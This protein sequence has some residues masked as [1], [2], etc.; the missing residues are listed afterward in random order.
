ATLATAALV[1]RLVSIVEPSF[2][3]FQARYAPVAGTDAVEHASGPRQRS[4]GASAP[5]DPD[6]AD[7]VVPQI[8]RFGGVVRAGPQ[9][10]R[11]SAAGH[12]PPAA[13][14]RRRTGRGTAR[15][16]RSTPSAAPTT[17]P[18][19]RRATPLR[20]PGTGPARSGQRSCA[21]RRS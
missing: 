16:A 11:G 18:W 6:A 3:V 2:G 20:S 5:S 13:R 15:G 12:R 9:R 10:G 19:A 21:T 14:R 7:G 17:A 8:N 4:Q 1:G